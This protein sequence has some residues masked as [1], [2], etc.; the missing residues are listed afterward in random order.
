MG[1][2]IKIKKTKTNKHKK[3]PLMVCCYDCKQ[4]TVGAEKASDSNVWACPPGENR[5]DR[6]ETGLT[7]GWLADKR[8]CRPWAES[9]SLPDFSRKIEGDSARRVNWGKR[10]S[11]FGY[12]LTCN[13]VTIT[14]Y[15][16][17]LCRVYLEDIQWFKPVELFTK[18]GRRGHIK[19]P[20][21]EQPTCA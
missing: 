5:F 17:C 12:H 6:F 9:P 21:G 13:G 3:K 4:Y 15:L 1:M 2:L 14:F 19:E 8:K 7:H 18:Y 11:F 16:S 20:L 10:V